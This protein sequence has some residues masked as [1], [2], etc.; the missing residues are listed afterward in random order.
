MLNRFNAQIYLRLHMI[1]F[2][3]NTL[4]LCYH[5]IR[6]VSY[7]LANLGLN[8]LKCNSLK[9]LIITYNRTRHKKSDAPAALIHS[10]HRAVSSDDTT[11]G[12]FYI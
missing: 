2:F 3:E 12:C 6:T 1:I 8:L 11:P 5:F 4:T 9:A 7:D 10:Y